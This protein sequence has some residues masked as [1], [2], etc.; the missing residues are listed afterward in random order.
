M[1]VN[2]AAHPHVTEAVLFPFDDVSIPLT[3]GLQLSMV[4]GRKEGVVLGPEGPGRA[5]SRLVRYYGTVIRI[6]EQFRMWYLGLGDTD[7]IY[8]LCYAVSADG[9]EWERPELGLVSY[10]GDSRNNLV[11]LLRDPHSIQLGPIL[12]D[13]DDPDPD[14]RF[15]IAFETDK[16]HQRLAVAYSPDGLRWT[17]SGLRV[18]VSWRDRPTIETD[19][20]VR[21]K[22]NFGGLRP[23]DIRVY[24]VYVG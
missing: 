18:P 13:P 23:E 1:Q 21:V 17:E 15:K 20:P 8:R 2:S 9:R 11:D 12:H 22:V 16:Y 10:G 5:D 14:R 7:D 6:G 3:Y 19:S 4:P 24:A